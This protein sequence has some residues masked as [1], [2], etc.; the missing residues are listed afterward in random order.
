MQMS[1]VLSPLHHIPNHSITLAASAVNTAMG[2]SPVQ[3][4]LQHVPNQSITLAASAVNTAMGMSPVQSPLQHVPNQSITLAASLVNTANSLQQGTMSPQP[5]QFQSLTNPIGSPAMTIDKLKMGQ[6]PNMTPSI[7]M[8]IPSEVQMGEISPTGQQVPIHIFNKLDLNKLK[9]LQSG[10]PIAITENQLQKIQQ[11]QMPVNDS[12]IDLFGSG[13]DDQL[14]NQEEINKQFE[15]MKKSEDIQLHNN[16][17][18]SKKHFTPESF[19]KKYALSGSIECNNDNEVEILEDDETKDLEI[20]AEDFDS[21]SK[22][23][24]GDPM[25]QPD[26]EDNRDEEDIPTITSPFKCKSTVNDGRSKS[27]PAESRIVQ[28]SY[29]YLQINSNFLYGL[30][31]FDSQD[32]YIMN[33]IS[34]TP[35]IDEDGFQITVNDIL[36]KDDDESD[37]SPLFLSA[38]SVSKKQQNVLKSAIPTKRKLDNRPLETPPPKVRSSTRSKISMNA[39]D[40][41]TTNFTVK[42]GGMSGGLIKV[43]EE[44]Q[45]RNQ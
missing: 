11:G 8:S 19:Q 6:S 27:A 31:N 24:Y 45:R 16:Q 4:P 18:D 41:E 32:E 30:R 20:V 37:N 42:S 2:M 10:S 15:P 14:Q 1:P 22:D 12:Q 39:N 29:H 28:G 17:I 9:Q 23:S 44:D 33:N 34:E 13:N 43:R 36:R 26:T 40:K 5:N 25:Y 21:T 38:L 7:Q 3:S 35:I